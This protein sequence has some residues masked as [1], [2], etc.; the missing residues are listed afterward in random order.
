MKRIFAVLF[1]FSMSVSACASINTPS[2]TATPTASAPTATQTKCPIATLTL[3]PSPTSTAWLPANNV[4]WCLDNVELQ[5]DKVIIQETIETAYQYFVEQLGVEPDPVVIFAGADYEALAT[6]GKCKENGQ[7]RRARRELSTI[8]EQ[9][10]GY[11][12]RDLANTHTDYVL[13]KQNE[14]SR[15]CIVAHEYAH[16][17]QMSLLN[18]EIDGYNAGPGW[19]TEGS[20]EVLAS[21][22]Q[23]SPLLSKNLLWKRIQDRVPASVQLGQGG[24]YFYELST[25][26]VYYLIANAPNGIHSIVTY[27]RSNPK[28]Q[29]WRRSFEEAFGITAKQFYVDFE[30]YRKMKPQ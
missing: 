22:S 4:T 1:L 14:A 30:N 11:T 9:T 6:V 29:T 20:A 17:L 5:S 12:L 27:F 10:G 23:G 16:V 25:C 7:L 13:W 24:D 8:W 15:R 28:Y 2:Y 3:M 21:A 18:R 19:L 26:A